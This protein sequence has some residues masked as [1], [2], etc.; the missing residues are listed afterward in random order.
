LAEYFMGAALLRRLR[1]DRLLSPRDEEILSDLSVAASVDAARC[2]IVTQTLRLQCVPWRDM[3]TVYFYDPP[4]V[5]VT[6]ELRVLDLLIEL[7]W[8]DLSDVPEPLQEFA[9]P[10]ESPKALKNRL[11]DLLRE[12]AGLD[13]SA[14][15]VLNPGF[16]YY[17]P[18]DMNLAFVR[19]VGR[20]GVN[21]FVL[22][23]MK[24]D[25]VIKRSLVP[26]HIHPTVRDFRLKPQEA[27]PRS[28]EEIAA[29]WNNLEDARLDMFQDA[30][31]QRY[32]ILLTYVVANGSPMPLLETTTIDVERLI[33]YMEEQPNKDIPEWTRLDEIPGRLRKIETR[34]AH[35]VVSQHR[36]KRRRSANEARA[37]EREKEEDEIFIS[38]PVHPLLIPQ[39]QEA[40]L[41]LGLPRKVYEDPEACVKDAARSRQFIDFNGQLKEADIWEFRSKKGGNEFLDS[42]IY[43]GR[44]NNPEPSWIGRVALDP[45]TSRIIAVPLM[46]VEGK[47][48][49]RPYLMSEDRFAWI[50]GSS[51]RDIVD[52]NVFNPI[53]QRETTVQVAMN[54]IHT[55]N[56]VPVPSLPLWLQPTAPKPNIHIYKYELRLT[57]E[58]NPWDPFAE[59]I[60]YNGAAATPH[61]FEDWVGWVGRVKFNNNFSIRSLNGASKDGERTGP[62]RIFEFLMAGG[63]H[64]VQ[65]AWCDFDALRP[66][67]LPWNER[68]ELALPPLTPFINPLTGERYHH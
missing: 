18:R 43:R 57:L 42:P 4:F 14:Y 6:R 60:L 21:T 13:V 55:T 34:H 40:L 8:G 54:M 23:V 27:V 25:L 1:R 64:V 68:G 20:D 41:A 33:Q 45:E 65:H 62:R 56:E 11:R 59:P 51:Q 66:L 32:K 17:P 38:D 12:V 35:L 19:S 16:V 26:T 29:P 7:L 28:E 46:C 63:D 49:F 47:W 44:Y 3:L 53:L 9:Q 48:R 15:H 37:K 5:G 30:K 50:G 24:G 31:D 36:E 52:M 22:V 58:L 67:E 2:D 39:N 10:E 61:R